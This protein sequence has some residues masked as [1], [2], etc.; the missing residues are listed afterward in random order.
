MDSSS[1][2]IRGTNTKITTKAFKVWLSEC[3]SEDIRCVVQRRDTNY[4][5]LI[6]FNKLVSRMVLDVEVLNLVMPKLILGEVMSGVIV[7]I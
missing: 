6:E 3:L 7:A 4:P 1:G 5:K 2:H